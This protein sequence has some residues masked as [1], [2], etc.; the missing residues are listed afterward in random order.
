M[1]YIVHRSKCCNEGF[2]YYVVLC[3]IQYWNYRQ[4]PITN[5]THLLIYKQQELIITKCYSD[6]A[7]CH[8]KLLLMGSLLFPNSLPY[9]LVQFR[10]KPVQVEDNAATAAESS[11]TMPEE[12]DVAAEIDTDAESLVAEMTIPSAMG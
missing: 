10:A 6:R 11:D 3:V 1:Q 5:F 2:Y 9:S 12:I 7:G 4:Y 8:G